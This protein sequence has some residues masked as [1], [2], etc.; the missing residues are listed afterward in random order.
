MNKVLEKVKNKCRLV[1]PFPKSAG[2]IKEFKDWRI[3]LQETYPRRYRL[4]KFLESMYRRVL[5]FPAW[6]FRDAKWAMLHRFHPKHRYHVLKPR[7]LK[8]GYIDPCEML[9]HAPFDLF[10]EFFEHTTG[11]NGH[12]LWDYTNIEPDESCGRTQDEIDYRQNLWL[13][14]NE[15]YN[16]WMERPNRVEEELPDLPEEWGFM[17]IFDDDYRDEPIVKE[18]RVVSDRRTAQDEAWEKE[19]QDMLHKLIDIRKHLWD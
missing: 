5:L 14:M 3:H 6:R 9:L 12:T 2:T 18:W 17:A 15:L 11:P 10:A 16:W 7:T 1:P 4:S 8:P 19:D 13:T